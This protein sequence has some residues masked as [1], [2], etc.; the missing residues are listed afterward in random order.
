MNKSRFYSGIAS[1]SYSLASAAN[2]RA[3]RHRVP[4]HFRHVSLMLLIY[5][6]SGAAL[7]KIEITIDPQYITYLDQN[8]FY[9]TSFIGTFSCDSTLYAQTELCYRG[10]YTLFNQIRFK[11]LQRNWKVKTAKL[12]PY[13]DY[14]VWNYNYEPFLSHNLA[15]ELMRNAGVPCAGMRQVIFYVNG[16][17]HGLYSEF[18]DP[19]NKKWLK[20]TFG[21]TSDALVGDL[22]KAATDKPNLPQKYFADLTVLGVND[23]D[24]YLHYNKK[25]NDST[26]Q[27]EGDCSSIRNFI[28]LLNETPDNRFTD[29]IDRYFDVITFLKYLTVANYIDF[30][31]GY[32]N[33]AKNYW[34][35]LNPHTN[36][37][38][39]IPWDMDETFNPVRALYNN[40]GMECNYL[41]MYNQTNLNQ[42]YTTLYQTSNNGK[43]EITPRPLFTRIMN[44]VKYRDLYASLYKGALSTYLKKETVQGKL[45]SIAGVVRQAGLSKADSL[46]IDTSITNITLFIQKR[47]ASLENQLGAISTKQPFI[48]KNSVAPFFLLAVRGSQWNMTNNYSI[49]IT[50]TLFQTNG[51]LIATFSVP[52]K[53]KRS[54]G[55]PAHGILIYNIKGTAGISLSRGIVNTR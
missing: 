11:L 46:D 2:C 4:G 16:V 9:D 3:F 48:Q 55:I 7:D 22:Y 52:P 38:V 34:L 21:D 1:L 25:T 27:T 53:S 43:S 30:W 35:Y 47:T 10:A 20:Q 37:W 8:P 40:M 15:Y 19:D 6:M 42:Y 45:D 23:S 32:P 41:F 17:K 5:A 13:R 54:I 26:V 44:V 33:R 49:P 31:D 51:R 36:K 14:H 12:Q 29:T 28:K 50:C 18:P 39:F 24:Y